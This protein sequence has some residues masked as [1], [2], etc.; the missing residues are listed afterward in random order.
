M[1]FTDSKAW[2]GGAAGIAI[3]VTTPGRHLWGHVQVIKPPTLLG[4]LRGHGMMSYPAVN[5]VQYRFTAE[6]N[7]TRLGILASR[8]GSDRGS[9]SR[10]HAP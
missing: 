5:H 3:W 7:G 9:A 10:R 8:H 4:N 2:P 6:G 1:P